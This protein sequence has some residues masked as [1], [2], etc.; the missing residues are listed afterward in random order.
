VQHFV[1]AFVSEREPLDQAVA[2]LF[3]RRF[4]TMAVIAFAQTLDGVNQGPD[5]EGLLGSAG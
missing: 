5:I 3:V 1:R 2:E 4:A